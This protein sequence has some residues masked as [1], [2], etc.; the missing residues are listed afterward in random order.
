MIRAVIYARYSSD[1]QSAASI[2]DQIRLC[3]QRVDREGWV[4]QQTYEDRAASGA[5]ALRSAYQKLLEDARSRKFDVV[6]AEALDRLSR[7]QED[8]AALYKRLKFAGIRLITLAEG[9]ITELH[10]GLKGTMNALFIKDLADKTRRGLRGR[11]EAGFSAGGNSFGY[12]VVRDMDERGLPMK[13]KRI[14]DAGEA[15]VV[16]RIFREFAAGHS[17]RAIAKRLNLDDVG[18][19][20]N[21]PWADTTIRGH[22]TRGTG[23]LHNELYIGRLVWNRQRYIKDPESGKRLARPNP[24]AEWIVQE[25]PELRIIPN[26]LW[27]EV[28]ARLRHIRESPGVQKIRNNGFWNRRRAKHLITGR[29]FCGICG[30]AM[31]AAGKDYLACGTA[32]RR[33]TC[34]NRTS[35][36]RPALE[37]TVIDALRDNLMQP[38]L[39]EE[40]IRAF[41]EETNRMHA[42]ADQSRSESRRELAEVSRRLEG[43]IDAIAEGLRTPGLKAKLVELEGRKALL[44][45]E[46]AMAPPP[47]PRLHPNLAELYRRKVEDLQ[48]ALSDPEIRTEAAEILRGLIEAINVRPTESG[49]EIE[50]VGDIASMVRVANDEG[51]NKKAAP[52]GAAVRETFASS[53]K[54]VAGAGFEPTTFRL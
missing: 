37:A 42:I 27:K 46:I 4:C 23:V 22:A 30:A 1:L 53:V 54:V 11:V 39:V 16:R 24:P 25:A 49:P 38:P 47:A 50:L 19:P 5:S 35:I 12:R 41:T 28:Q 7:D 3:R 51:R 14:I 44:E 36:R 2:E 26:A 31:I 52:E 17:P 40:F 34:T 9:D 15:E 32:R 18:G 13:G 45:T 48:A 8:V 20:G 33:G 6:V 10:V 21:R 43:L 29:V